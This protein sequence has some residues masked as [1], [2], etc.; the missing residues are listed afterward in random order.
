MY[1]LYGEYL[2]AMFSAGLGGPLMQYT[3][4]GACW[5]LK[6][7]TNDSLSNSPQYRAV[8]DFVTVHP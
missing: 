6:E 8:T 1:A 3:A 5:G 4:V 7:K 2:D